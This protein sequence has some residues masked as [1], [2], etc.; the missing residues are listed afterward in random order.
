MRPFLFSISSSQLEQ[1]RSDHESVHV[2]ETR[3]SAADAAAAA[4]RGVRAWPYRT[5]VSRRPSTVEM[6]DGGT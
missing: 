5:V 1:A 4:Y 3:N 6:L 2:H